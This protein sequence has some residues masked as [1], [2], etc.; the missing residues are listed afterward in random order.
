MAQINKDKTQIIYGYKTLKPGFEHW[1]IK[2]PSTYDTK[3]I[4]SIE[5]AYSL[6]ARDAGIEVP[7]THL[8]TTPK[9]MYFGVKR[10]DRRGDARIHMHSLCGLIHADFRTPSLDYDLFLR[11]V[12]VLTK[13]KGDVEKAFSL[14][15]FNV[16]AHNRDDHSKNFSFLLDD[17]YQWKLAPA[18][19]LTF[20]YG[21][22]G[23]QST[24][25][26]GEGRD[27]SIKNL[28]ELG[29]KHGLKKAEMLIEQVKHAVGAW[30]EH[31]DKAQVMQRTTK[32]ISAR[33]N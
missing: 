4:A 5:Y 25:V 32:D 12:W 8:F 23:E 15:C 24:T 20:S 2:F 29:Q 31:A 9:G 27:P 11:L 3:D 21:P 1:L 6:M 16:L 17:D 18:Y 7:E 10:F 19:D 26:M 28:R 30:A 22:N 33:L 14:A 13:N